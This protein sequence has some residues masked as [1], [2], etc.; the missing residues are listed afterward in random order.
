M[1]GKVWFYLCPHRTGFNSQAP[2]AFEMGLLPEEVRKKVISGTA[3]NK[4]KVG[5]EG[6]SKINSLRV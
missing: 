1:E 2:Y 5:G 6:I 3:K 4:R